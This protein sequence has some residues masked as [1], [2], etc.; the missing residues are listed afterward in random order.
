MNIVFFGSSKFAVPSLEEIAR[1]GYNIA[2]VVTQPDKKKGRGLKTSC[3]P[4]KEAA[5]KLGLKVYQPAQ[6]KNEKETEFLRQFQADLFV[7][8]A[9]GKILSRE[10]LN[11]PKIFSVNL[12]ASL[13]PKYRGAAPIN[14]AII[15]GE[16]K[17]GVSI[18]SM[19]E[20]MDQ[21]E[22][23]T[24][25]AIEIVEDDTESILED[26][27]SLIGAGLL[28]KTLPEIKKK[29]CLLI[30]QDDKKATLAPKLSKNDGLIDWSKPAADIKNLIRGVNT[31]PGAFTHYKTKILK[32]YSVEIICGGPAETPGKI[33]QATPAGIVVAT[34]KDKLLIKEL[35]IEGKRKMTAKDFV[36]GHKVISGQ[37]LG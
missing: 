31:W 15:R 14:W 20:R 34:G 33:I 37:I 36:S 5:I 28:L 24:Q 9:Y 13:L 8:I 32:I 1:A 18:I 3:T 7:V 23:I 29:N 27:L 16:K 26:K 2:C 11:I 19:N 10:I 4:V 17:T 21:G 6:L 25:E 12:H 22:I 35:Q 30:A